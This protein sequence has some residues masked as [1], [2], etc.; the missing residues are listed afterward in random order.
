M[1]KPEAFVTSVHNYNEDGTTRIDLRWQGN[2]EIGDFEVER[3]GQV[4]NL[5]TETEDTGWI[6]VEYPGNAKAGDT[7]PVRP[8]G[9]ST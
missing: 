5:E 8:E 9:S 2:Y 1:E 3:L 7:I 6:L 4:L